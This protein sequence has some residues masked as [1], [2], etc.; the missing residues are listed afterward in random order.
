MLYYPSFEEGGATKNLINI[1]N[2]FVQKKIRVFLFSYKVD[3]K[4]FINNNYLKII[5][6]EPIKQINFLPIRWNLAISSVLNL[7]SYIK[8]YKKDSIVFSMQSHIPAIIVSKLN[9]IKISIRNSEEPLGATKYADNKFLALLVLLLKIIF[10]NFSDQIIAISKKSENSLKKLVLFKN[11]VHLILNPYLKKIYKIKKRKKNKYF[12]ILSVGR[13]TKQKNFDL[14]IDCIANLS[15]R[16]KNIRLTIIGNGDQYDLIKNKTSNY[17][18]INLIKWKKNLKKFFLKSD[19][20]ILP[21]FYEGL[22]NTL[23]D[24]VNYE[25]PSIATDVS[26]VKDILING[27][28]GLIVPNNDQE[29]LENNIE[30]AIKNYSKVKAKS[31][32]AKK[33]IYRFT[34]IN[35]VLIHK[36][37]DKLNN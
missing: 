22:P 37:F 6:S 19:L 31:I 15:K 29:K 12:Y 3:K 36:L 13:I 21:S 5:K 27:K 25:V 26:G 2:Y 20:F 14:L 35:C 8:Q 4:N 28:G 10:Y 23:I 33:Q 18:F 24:A 1:V 30:Y 34:K 17:N 7:N 16:Y 32:L 9:G 11:K